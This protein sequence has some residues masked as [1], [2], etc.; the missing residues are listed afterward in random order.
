MMGNMIAR[1]VLIL[2]L[3]AL[4]FAVE[5]QQPTAHPLRIGWLVFG[6]PFS[7]TSP[8]LEA[9][10]LVGLRGLGYVDGST[11]AIEYR[12]ARGQ[13]E[14][15]A[16][17]A[18]ELARSKVDILT[19]IGGDVAAALQKAT[20]TIPIV[21]AM[22]TDPVR[23]QLAASFARPG[24]NLTGVSFLFDELAAKRVELFRE[25]LPKGSR[26][27]VLWDPSHVDN[28]F[29]EV[30]TAAR[31]LNIKLQSIELRAPAD[32]DAAIQA[33]A[34]G[35]M[36]TLIVVPARLT[37]FLSRRIIDAAMPHRIPVI[38]GWR[39][40]AERGAVMTYGPNR[41]ESAK[42][43]AV[44]IDKIVKGAKPGDLP[45]EQPTTFELVI[46]LKTA[47][48]LGLTIPPSLLLRADQVIE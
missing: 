33:A 21:V 39:E 18:A 13:S 1:L 14:R 34:E 22:S 17:L 26:L 6:S 2:I 15:L 9:S 23:S 7:E 28:D 37:S 45:I 47:K 10:M 30:R 4:P 20:K 25:M 32:L 27:A 36:E 46:N 24:G 8:D 44:Y 29:A 19:G 16:D 35:R 42:R 11:L 41:V 31:R 3:L 43:L 48:A 12:Y 40:F 38:S 5:A